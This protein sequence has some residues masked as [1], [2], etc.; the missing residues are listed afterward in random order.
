M[1]EFLRKFRKMINDNWLN[2]IWVIG[3]I[4]GVYLD[5]HFFSDKVLMIIAAP[6]FGFFSS[7]IFLAV[8]GLY[9]LIIYLF[10]DSIKNFIQYWKNL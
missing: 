4:T 1:K 5:F 10:Q 2:F 3:F 9:C 7:M 6:I 8:Y